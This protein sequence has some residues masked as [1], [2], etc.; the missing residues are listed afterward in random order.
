MIS[1]DRRCVFVANDMGEAAVVA[2]WLEHE[3][4]AAKVMDE[5]TLG[6]LE[7]LTGFTG[8][9]SRGV[10]VWSLNEDDLD[11][12]RMLI[13]EKEDLRSAIS[14]RK[15]AKGPVQAI[16]EECGGAS[17]FPGRNRDTTQDCPHCGQYMDVVD[18]DETTLR[19]A[20][21]RHIV[22][23]NPVKRR[24]YWMQSLQKP[25]IL[26]WLAVIA[27][28]VCIIVIGAVSGTVADP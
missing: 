23:S 21:R 1:R 22:Q 12:A 10:E 4:I 26:I 2:N 13:A 17:E 11:R 8:V 5:M 25:F 15:E 14:S 24:R 27:A 9:S 19:Q 28:V 18:A 20:T 3:G 7:G 6:G 16:C